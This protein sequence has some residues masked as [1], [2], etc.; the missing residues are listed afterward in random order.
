MEPKVTRKSFRYQSELV[1]SGERHGTASVSGKP[2]VAM[3]SPPEFKG[4]AACWSPEDMF[5]ASLNACLL[6]TFLA[7]AQREEL[8]LAGYQSSGEGRLEFSDGKY[9]FTEVV[10]RPRLR[11]KA[12]DDLDLAK[13]VLENAHRDCII[14]NSVSAAVKVEPEITL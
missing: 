13:M 11:V 7:Y 6:M 3:S 9:R 1:W 14:S 2:D 4:D 5:V 12:E 8:E 10:L